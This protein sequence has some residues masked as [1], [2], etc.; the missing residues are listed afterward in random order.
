MA[1]CNSAQQ[2]AAPDTRAAADEALI[3]KADMDWVNAAKSKK[4]DDWVAFYADDAVVLP[5]NDKTAS[6]KNGVRKASGDLLGLPGLAISWTPTKIE[7]ARA[8]DI[9][10]DYGTYELSF[11]DAAGKPITDRGKYVEIWKK[12][13]DG[14]WKV[15]V[16]TWSSDAPAAAPAS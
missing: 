9:A 2:P 7:V 4:V 6:T 14:N 13:A 8:G 3:R 5:P 12:Q 11:N 1:G 16:D 10:Y 15:I